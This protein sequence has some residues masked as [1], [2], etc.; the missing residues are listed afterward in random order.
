MVGIIDNGGSVVAKYSY[1]AWGNILGV[2]NGV[3]EPITETDHIANINPIRYRGY[4]YDSETGF[5]YLQSR[6]YDPVTQRFL[7]ADA[8]VAGVSASINGYNLFA[9]C[10]N[11]PVNLDDSEGNWPVWATIAIVAAAAVVVSGVVKAVVDR[12]AK[13]PIANHMKKKHV[14]TPTVMIDAGP[15]LGKVGTSSTVTSTH[16]DE[17][18]ALFHSYSDHGNDASKYAAGINVDWFGVDVGVSS[19]V[20]IFANVQ[21][22]PWVHTEIS[23]GLDGIGA[24]L[25]FT[26]DNVSQDFEIKGGLGLIAI[27]VA[28]E[29]VL[30]N[31]QYNRA[32][33]RV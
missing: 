6:Y 30:S 13:K 32:P 19:K 20:N 24:I 14:T 11:N 33:V 26:S 4:Y 15:V 22:T 2:T 3:G 7:N 21:L 8:V 28:P 16:E 17:E 1:D 23:V 12:K 9:Y 27:I 10:F 25:G 31:I 18:P 29:V 5:Y